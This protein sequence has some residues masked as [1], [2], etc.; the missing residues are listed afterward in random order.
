MI[1]REYYDLVQD[2]EQL[3][4]LL[5]AGSPN[6]PDVTALSTRIAPAKTRTLRL[7]MMRES[8]VIRLDST[9]VA[10]NRPDV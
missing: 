2:P 9:S 3:T 6:P 10:S 5:A 7:N 4:N 1:Y 8:S